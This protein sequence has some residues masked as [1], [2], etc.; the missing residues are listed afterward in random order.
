M[1]YTGNARNGRN[2]E[3]M[4]RMLGSAFRDP[5]M[6]K[7]F[8][9][10]GVGG[11]CLLLPLLSNP[12]RSPPMPGG[13]HARFGATPRRIY[14]HWGRSVRNS[15]SG[16]ALSV[17]H[18]SGESAEHGKALTGGDGN[19]FYPAKSAGTLSRPPLP[20]DLRLLDF[21]LQCAIDARSENAPGSHRCLSLIPQ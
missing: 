7:R 5:F 21:L 3:R 14:I 15:G 17:E 12:L 6:G 18:S 10:S 11:A 16:K 1:A 19:N 4:R 13:V 9:G 20:A 8:P 2:S